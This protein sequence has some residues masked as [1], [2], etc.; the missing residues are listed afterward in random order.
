MTR[1]QAQIC[2]GVVLRNRSQEC[3]DAAQ[4]ALL[5]CANAFSPKV[6]STC[7]GTAI[8]DLSGTE[9]LFGTWGSTAGAMR[10]TAEQRGFHLDIAVA[11]NPDAAFYAARGFRGITIIP[12]TQEARY[13][14][15]LDVRLLPVTPEML[16]TLTRWGIR[17]FNALGELPDVALSERLGQPGLHI[18]KLARGSVQRT[19]VPLADSVRFIEAH[20]FE[21]PVETLELLAVLLDQLLQLL[22][23]RLVERALA[24]NELRLA[25]ELAVTQRL[26][27]KRSERYEHSWKLPVATQN[28][29]MLLGILRLDLERNSFSAPICKV[30]V[31]AVA[32]R[33]RAAQGN[34]FAPP[35]PEP[36]SLELTLARLRGVVGGAEAGC[37]GSPA[38]LDTHKSDAFSIKVFSAISVASAVMA[39]PPKIMRRFRPALEATVD[40]AGEKPRAVRLWKK[41]CRVLAAF[42][43][44]CSSGNW[45]N[46]QAWAREDWDVALQTAAGVGFYRICQDRIKKRW[47]VEVLFD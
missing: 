5:D 24:T 21:D 7:P 10:E 13:L 35:S 23:M 26:G 6:E 17:T 8:L 22:C 40:L 38:I 28:A 20:E 37:I 1:L 9:R 44:W 18:Q 33:P 27:D 43:P 29:R 15:S 36:E 3:E 19:L 31:E 45:W 30:E 34:L 32:V 2:P 16:D 12:A 39:M 25:L 46:E 41:Q 4:A 14:K 47:F 42:G 11:S